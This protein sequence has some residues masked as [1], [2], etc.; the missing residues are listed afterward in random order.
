MH[1][2]DKIIEKAK[3]NS[4]CYNGSLVSPKCSNCGVPTFGNDCI[5]VK[6]SIHKQLLGLVFCENNCRVKYIQKHKIK[7]KK[8]I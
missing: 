5:I 7:P 3:T 4:G 1:K 8:L 6:K 2:L